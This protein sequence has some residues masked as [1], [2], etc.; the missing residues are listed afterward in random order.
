MRLRPE[1]RFIG[2]NAIKVKREKGE[3]VM[4]NKT[5]NKEKALKEKS[6][7]EKYGLLD[8]A[9]ELDNFIK[10]NDDY[11]AHI[12]MIGGYSAGKSALLNKKMIMT[13]CPAY[14]KIILF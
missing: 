5:I 7:A 9:A 10:K 6:I 2:I 8:Q 11:K 4:I 14:K 1:G 3:I 13:F 12:L